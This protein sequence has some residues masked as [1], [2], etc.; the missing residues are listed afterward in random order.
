MKNIPL[1]QLK[2]EIPHG[3]YC[4]DDRKTGICPYWSINK[5]YEHQ[6]NGYCSY[7]E[8]G[9]WMDDPRNKWGKP[10]DP[11]GQ[12]HMGLLWDQVKACGIND[13]EEDDLYDQDIKNDKESV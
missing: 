1:E 4:Y 11:N 12:L 9:D 5:E 13:N 7:L 8:L 3:I 2:Q 6:N 10:E